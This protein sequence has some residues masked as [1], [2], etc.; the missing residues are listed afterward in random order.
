MVKTPG[1]RSAATAALAGTAVQERVVKVDRG[2]QSLM[3][4]GD[5]IEVSKSQL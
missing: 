5:N 3:D 2:L 4:Y 1:K